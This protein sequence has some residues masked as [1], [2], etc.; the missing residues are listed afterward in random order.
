MAAPGD[1]PGAVCVLSWSLSEE[2]QGLGFVVKEPLGWLWDCFA[3]DERRY[4]CGKGE[5]CILA[6]RLSRR[7]A[8]SWEDWSLYGQKQARVVETP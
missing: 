8:I 7:L 5:G 3:T 2:Q 1:G 4:V 6:C